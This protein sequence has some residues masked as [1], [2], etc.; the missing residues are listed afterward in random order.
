GAILVN[1][2]RGGVID[3]TALLEALRSGGLRAAALD[4]FAEEPLPP[5][6]PLLALPNV[7][8]S[9]HIAFYSEES[10]EQMRRDAAEQ[11]AQALEGSVPAF[12]VNREVLARNREGAG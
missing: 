11:V 10:L 9:G 3:E 12:L 2:S 7:T 4:V 5:T 8:V 1:T 6:H